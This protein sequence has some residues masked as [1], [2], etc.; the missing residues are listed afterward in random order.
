MPLK[1]VVRLRREVYPNTPAVL[2]LHGKALPIYPTKGMK[3][4]GPLSP[5]LFLFYHKGTR[6]KTSQPYSAARS[7]PTTIQLRRGLTPQS[8]SAIFQPI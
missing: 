1:P 4:G 3:E 8:C 7:T 2:S 5:R 6:L